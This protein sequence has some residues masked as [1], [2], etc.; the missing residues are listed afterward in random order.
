MWGEQCGPNTRGSPP[1]RRGGP[2]CAAG[3]D[4]ST[5]AAPVESLPAVEEPLVRQVV[6]TDDALVITDE[7]FTHSD[8][9]QSGRFTLS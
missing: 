2:Q 9:L 5:P 8:R 3:L 1:L 4:A 6:L 7:S